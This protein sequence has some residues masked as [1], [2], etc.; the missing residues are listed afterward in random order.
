LLAT[1]AVH[2]FAHIAQ[3]A[4]VLTRH[5]GAHAGPWRAH[6]SLLR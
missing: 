3:I 1:W 5:F 2:D 4:R 6:F